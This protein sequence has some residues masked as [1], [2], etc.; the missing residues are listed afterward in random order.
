MRNRGLSLAP[1]RDDLIAPF[2]QVFDDFFNDFF[3]SDLTT[4]VKNSTGFPKMD[5]VEADGKFTVSVAA[6]G[7]TTDDLDVEVS[8][9]NVL[10]IRG[11]MNEEHRAPEGATYYLRELRMS[12]FERRIKLPDHIK[13]DPHAVMKDGLLTLSWEAPVVQ[14]PQSRKIAIETE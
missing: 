3:R 5:V 8:P 9:D 4:R 14:E 7:M 13:G 1:R 11:K 10:T 12:A 2:E 6:S